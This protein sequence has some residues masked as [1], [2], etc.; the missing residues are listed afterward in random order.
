M[1]VHDKENKS[2]KM[3]S[4]YSCWLHMVL[5]KPFQVKF[6]ISVFQY[7]QKILYIIKSKDFRNFLH[8]MLVNKAHHRPFFTVQNLYLGSFKVIHTTPANKYGSSLVKQLVIFRKKDIY[9]KCL[10]WSSSV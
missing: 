7:V 4:L 6:R 8:Q 5:K 2:F 10:P 3:Y 1:T 9:Y